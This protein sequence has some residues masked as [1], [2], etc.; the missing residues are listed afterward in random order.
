[1]GESTDNRFGEIAVQKGWVQPAQIENALQQIQS[2]TSPRKIRL[3][4]V[5]VQEEILSPNQVVSIL[6][7]QQKCLIFC[8]GCGVRYNFP[9][10]MQVEKQKCP[11]CQDALRPATTVRLLEDVVVSG[12]F[13]KRP[14]QKASK[15]PQ[16]IPG[17][18]AQTRVLADPNFAKTALATKPPD[19]LIGRSLGRARLRQL[20]GQGGM[21]SVYI[22]LHEAL[23]RDIVVK[24]L[25]PELSRDPNLVKRFRVEAQSCAHLNHEN[26]VHIYD[27]GSTEDGVH[28]ISMEFI[29]GITLQRRLIDSGGQLRIPEALELIQQIGRGLEAAH[30]EKII[31]RDIKPENIMITHEGKVKVMDFGL[32]KS[33]TRDSGL[34]ASGQILGT[35]YFMSPEQ[36][37]GRKVDHRS[38]I[39]SLGVVLYYLLTGQRPFTGPSPASIIVKH[40]NEAPKPPSRLLN[41]LPRPLEKIILRAMAKTVE[42]RYQT[43]GEFLEDLTRFES[44]ELDSKVDLAVVGGYAKKVG[45]AGWI[46]GAALIATVLLFLAMIGS[47]PESPPDEP[48]ETASNPPTPSV[49]PPPET[50]DPPKA[51]SKTE[52][53]LNILDEVNANLGNGAKVDRIRRHIGGIRLDVMNGN[54]NEAHANLRE[55]RERALQLKHLPRSP[56]LREK[57]EELIDLLAAQTPNLA[58][59]PSVDTIS[60]AQNA[61]EKGDYDAALNLFKKARKQAQDAKDP[62]Q[63]KLAFQGTTNCLLNKTKARAK[64]A[65]EVIQDGEIEKAAGILR[66]ITIEFEDI[67][68]QR[69]ES[70]RQVADNDLYSY[71]NLHRNL[72]AED[73][74]QNPPEQI[75]AQLRAKFSP[76]AWYYHWRIRKSKDGVGSALD[77]MKESRVQ[78][79]D[80][81]FVDAFR[82]KSWCS[83]R[84]GPRDQSSSSTQKKTLLDA[85]FKGEKVTLSSR[86]LFSDGFLNLGGKSK[87]LIDHVIDRPPPTGFPIS[88]PFLGDQLRVQKLEGR[89]RIQ[90]VLFIPP[91]ERMHGSFENIPFL[92][93]LLDADAATI[94][95]IRFRVISDKKNRDT[96]VFE[97]QLIAVTKKSP[98]LL[99]RSTMNTMKSTLSGLDFENELV[100]QTQRFD[101]SN[102]PLGPHRRP[103]ETSLYMEFNFDENRMKAFVAI[104]GLDGVSDQKRE[105]SLSDDSNNQT[106]LDLHKNRTQLQAI[107]IPSPSRGRPLFLLRELQISGT[108]CK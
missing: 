36:C 95:A 56:Q 53:V 19:T 103:Q 13:Q 38:D 54:L 66:E 25:P 73:L 50:T 81:R 32:A 52:R 96:R 40:L 86:Q 8:N 22:A 30:R 87:E 90:T 79:L 100:I 93:L 48:P 105:L 15:K 75:E 2:N 61:Y 17:T 71:Q 20:I 41:D 104:R 23:D 27:V 88:F 33:L 24:V 49:I 59:Q 106:L 45:P 69:S 101:S 68:P 74:L 51:E 98:R 63:E 31:H 3:G 108:P 102:R 10:S 14:P 1:M 84:S 82:V 70:I 37:D 12:D 55:L 16:T 77:Q 29:D 43:M 80:Q 57:I 18:M 34:T 28:Y 64:L 58:P 11:Q 99:T 94:P 72:Q 65:W 44:G 67:D 47:N 42:K 83:N 46:T 7:E 92:W 9:R 97:F 107:L 60:Q 76:I 26:I 62:D 39:Y 6:E 91:H 89:I 78:S 21:G 5:L 4:E 35:P 85:Y